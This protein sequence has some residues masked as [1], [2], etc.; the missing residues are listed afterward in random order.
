M[1]RLSGLD[2]LR[3]VAIVWVM[4]FHSYIVGRL[5]GTLGIIG[6]YGWAG[7]D[8]FFVL[9]GYLIG[10]QVLK[11]L[12]RGQPLSFADF[13]IRRAFRIVPVL[14]VVLT[15]YFAWPGLREAPGI[16]PLWQYLT[17]TFNFL[18]D[19]EHNKAFSHFWSLCVEEHF[20]LLFPLIAVTMLRKPS[21]RRFALACIVV[22]AG[23]MLVRAVVWMHGAD[24]GGSL[25]G[26]YF[27]RNIYYPTYARLDGLLAGVILASCRMYRPTWWTRLQWMGH[28]IT[29]CGVAALAAALWL[30]QD[31]AGLLASALGYPLLSAGM[32]LLVIAAS[33]GNSGLARVHIP[34][35]E[36]LARVSY[37]LYLSHKL[38][39]HFVQVRFAE[40]LENHGVLLFMV[41]AVAVLVVGALLYYGVE[42]PFLRLRDRLLAGRTAESGR[43]SPVLAG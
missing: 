2:L 1:I 29:V 40:A 21:A 34:G 22:A 11:P 35:V 6:D 27:V 5:P 16:Q 31:R 26:Q 7:V 38:A 19:Y 23:G 43:A 14:L 10:S 30:F 9:S 25:S 17:F 12:S 42:L 20:Y 33:G 39:L 4:L 28:R 13:Y 3:A 41:Y 15:A 24:G 37:S 32:A 18:V 36:W 8:L